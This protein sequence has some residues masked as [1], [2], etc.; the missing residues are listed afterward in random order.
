MQKIHIDKLNHTL[1]REASANGL[2]LSLSVT[3]RL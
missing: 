1:S 2:L 3:R